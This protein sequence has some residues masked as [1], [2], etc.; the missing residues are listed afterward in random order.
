MDTSDWTAGDILSTDQVKLE[1]IHKNHQVQLLG[2]VVFRSCWARHIE[3]I[4]S[5]G[6]SCELLVVSD[7]FW[8]IYNLYPD[9]PGMGGDFN[10]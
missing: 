4:T 7:Y 8:G 2:L 1:G 5:G 10:A 3:E 9:L 6:I